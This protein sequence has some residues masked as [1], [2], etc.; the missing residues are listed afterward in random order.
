MSHLEQGKNEAERWFERYMRDHGYEYDYEPDLGVSTRPDFLVWRAD[1]QMVC[2]VKGFD[3]PTP[4][5]RRLRGTS[6]TTMISADEEYGPMRNAVR[7]AA[8]Q[9]K[10]LAGSE[11]AWNQASLSPARHDRLA[12]RRGHRTTQARHRPLASGQK[13]RNPPTFR[14]TG[15]DADTFS[16]PPAPVKVER[17]ARGSTYNHGAAD[18]DRLPSRRAVVFDAP[19]SASR[20][21]AAMRGGHQLSVVAGGGAEVVGDRGADRVLEL[22]DAGAQLIAQAG[23]VGVAAD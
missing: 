15:F 12:S 13:C 7:E 4:L 22:C 8:R 3:Q 20:L 17:S 18:N 1:A 10:P 11:Y 16:P 23:E 14:S 21:E 2:E 6:H 19:P 5:E 9:L